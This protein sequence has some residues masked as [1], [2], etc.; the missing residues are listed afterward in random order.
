MGLAGCGTIFPILAPEGSELRVSIEGRFV[1]L[2]DKALFDQWS[3]SR[4]GDPDALRKVTQQYY[5]FFDDDAEILIVTS[6]DLKRG[7]ATLRIY[8][9]TTGLGIDPI[10]R[11]S[12]FGADHS[13]SLLITLYGRHEMTVGTVIHEIAHRWANGLTGAIALASP[14]G[15][16]A[17]HWGYCDVHGQLGGWQPGTLE[18]LGDDLYRGVVAP[19]GYSVTTLPYAPLELYLMGLAPASEVPPVNVAVNASMT[20]QSLDSI[21][22]ESKELRTITIDDI[23]AANGARV[24]AYGDAPTDFTIAL[25]VLTPEPLS[26]ED[27]FYYEKA[28]D[29]LTRKDNAVLMDVFANVGEMTDVKL[30]QDAFVAA[31]LE[32]FQNFH[33][34]T[35]G[36]GTLTLRT[37]NELRRAPFDSGLK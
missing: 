2:V 1:N 19:N 16:S 13:L 35:G 20:E 8:N 4:I 9:D 6:P 33:R 15:V 3:E 30:E 22:F 12:E 21:T 18:S 25:I 29:F 5:D 34:A 28:I 11:R 7:G 10:D 32:K 37:A 26:I 14:P 31:G 23:I 17:G 36:R 27:H 24:P